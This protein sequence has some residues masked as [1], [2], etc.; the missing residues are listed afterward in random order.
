MDIFAKIAEKYDKVVIQMHNN[1]DADAIASAFGMQHYFDCIDVKSEII[2]FG[3]PINKPNLTEMINTLGIVVRNCDSDFRVGYD[4]LLL[5][6]DGQ[7]GNSNVHP[8]SAYD[9][10]CID[11]HLVENPYNYTYVDIQSNVGS[12][13]SIVLKYLLA[14][15]KHIPKEIATALYFGILMDTNNFIVKYTKVDKESKEYLDKLCEKTLISKL[16]RTSL[17]FEDVSVFA[18]AMF[19][20]DRYGNAIITH[21]KEVD[22]NVLG[23]ISDLLSEI[24]GIDIVVIYSTRDIGYKVSV[25]SYHEF[26][27]ADDVIQSLT[28][29]IGSG[30]GHL[31]KAGGIIENK[32]FEKE[33]GD[34]DFHEYMKSKLTKFKD[35][36]IYLEEGKD[37]PLELWGEHAF[38][39]AYK[40]L[41]K[42]R[43]FDLSTAFDEDKYIKVKTLEG[44][45]DVKC[46]NM[47]IF[48]PKGEAY[49]IHK[50]LF[51]TRYSLVSDP[52]GN[53]IAVCDYRLDSY[54]ISLTDGE[55]TINITNEYLLTMRVA[56]TTSETLVKFKKFPQA[57]KVRCNW[58]DLFIKKNGYLVY[59]NDDNYY[60]CD[61]E[62]FE[63]TYTTAFLQQQ[64][65][66][67]K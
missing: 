58:G 14:V 36:F 67:A 64:Q 21:I 42:V 38:G 63:I 50:D 11:H 32:L 1:P 37:K 7:R 43:Y 59:I 25:R 10:A 18:E 9:I 53:E 29:K 46:D 23:H 51:E 40:K 17:N 33:H 41:Y 2:Y 52:L 31:N 28:D 4:D 49:P 26:I 61:E 45:V 22:D 57:I 44:S 47:L 19:G 62:V 66:I 5:I 34:I 65:A 8:F 39:Q 3:N 55:T 48:G 27:S 16:A 13:S 24:A 20:I 15:T 6:M 56:E 35:N 12:C 30:G 60:L 54:G